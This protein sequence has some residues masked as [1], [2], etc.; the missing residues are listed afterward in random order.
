MNK[1]VRN[2]LIGASAAFAVVIAF[3]VAISH[4]LPERGT[5]KPSF[6]GM[7]TLINDHKGEENPYVIVEVVP[8]KRLAKLGYLVEGSEPYYYNE[9]DNTLAGWETGLE[10]Q[11]DAAARQK[12]MDGM[13][14]NL[15]SI[16]GSD[17]AL[18]YT[19]YKESYTSAK[20]YTELKLSRPEFLAKGTKGVDIVE[21]EGGEYVYDSSYSVAESDENGFHGDFDLNI[22]YYDV[23]ADN[24]YYNIGFQVLDENAD[25]SNGVYVINDVAMIDS[26]DAML[27]AQNVYHIEDVDHQIFSY[28]PPVDYENVEFEDGMFYELTFRY[29]TDLENND[30]TFYLPDLTTMSFKAD[31]TGQYGAVLNQEQ[32]YL[33]CP[34]EGHFV[35]TGENAYVYVGEGNGFY[36]LE[37]QDSYVLSSDVQLDHIYYT[38]GFSNNNLLR[39]SIFQDEK[40][41]NLQVKVVTPQELTMAIVNDADMLFLSDSSAYYHGEF[42]E[43]DKKNDLTA[44]AAYAIYAFAENNQ[45]PVIL[46]HNILSRADAKNLLKVATILEANDVTGYIGADMDQY[47]DYGA[48]EFVLIADDDH[49]FVSRNI[50][51]IPGDDQLTFL[52]NLSL[53]LCD[54]NGQKEDAFSTAAGNAGFGEIAQMMI[55]ENFIRQTENKATDVGYELFDQRITTATAVEYILS[56]INKREE[57]QVEELN[58]L[59]IEP[60]PY[61]VT[62]NYYGKIQENATAVAKQ[63]RIRLLLGVSDDMKL[64]ITQVSMAEFEGTVEDLC[65]YDV[66]YM[67]LEIDPKNS[68]PSPKTVTETDKNGKS[69]SVI[70]SD[71]NDNDMDGLV[72]TNIGDT[73]RNKHTEVL[74]TDYSNSKTGMYTGDNSM[75]SNAYNRMAGN[76]ITDEKLHALERVA[77]AGTPIILANNFLTTYGTSSEKVVYDYGHDANWNRD[78]SKNGYI[79][80]CSKVYTL[81]DDIKDYPNV[82]TEEELAS[83][84]GSTVYT[85]QQNLLIRY[86]ML[87]KPILTTKTADKVSGQNYV[88]TDGSTIKMDFS[89]AN[90]GSVNANATFDVVLYA[91]YNADGRFS[92]KTERIDANSYSVTLNGK[93]QD[94]T[95]KTFT[96]SRGE[97]FDDYCYELTPNNKNTTS[98]HLEYN[99]GSVFGLI[100]VKLKI[101]QSS[102]VNR[103][104]ADIIYFYHPNTAEKDTIRVLQLLPEKGFDQ[105]AFDM[106]LTESSE[107][108]FYVKY[109]EKYGIEKYKYQDGTWRNPY[110]Y[111][112]ASEASC[113]KKTESLGREAMWKALIASYKNSKFSEYIDYGV[114][115]GVSG[116]INDYTLDIDSVFGGDYC[117]VVLNEPDCLEDYDM[118]VLGFQDCYDFFAYSKAGWPKCVEENR[119]NAKAAYEPIHMF[120][121]SGKSVL[122][123]HDST[124]FFGKPGG[125]FSSTSWAVYTNE[126]MVPD[127]GMERYGV[128]SYLVD[129]AGIDNLTKGGKT[130]YKVSNYASLTKLKEEGGLTKSSYTSGELYDMVVD[131]ANQN[132][133]DVAYKPNSEKNVLVSQIH[134]LSDSVLRDEQY[135]RTTT[136]EMINEGQIL[137]YPYNLLSE[138]KEGYERWNSKTKNY[139]YKQAGTMTIASTH[140]QYFQLDMNADEDY[141]GESDTTV[142]FT[143]SGKKYDLTYREARNNYYVYTR[144]NITYSGVGHTNINPLDNSSKYLPEI[145]LYVNTLIAS[146]KGGTSKPTITIKQSDSSKSA[147]LSTV[148]VGTDYHIYGEKD[149]AEKGDTGSEGSIDYDYDDN[150]EDAQLDKPGDTE[151]LYFYISDT[152]R[153]NNGTKTIAV[154]YYQLFES[155]ADAKNH[156]AAGETVVNIGNEK[157][158]QY[159]IEKKWKTY[160]MNAKDEVA[161]ADNLKNGRIYCVK[162]PYGVL[163]EDQDYTKVRISVTTTIQYAATEDAL[164]NKVEKTLDVI[165]YDDVTVQ[166]AGLFDLE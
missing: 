87:G 37:Q 43:Y 38:G 9:N 154:N 144:G 147:D 19:E 65:K 46:D 153:V 27:E 124:S 12:Y 6:S 145:K 106:D 136:A 35:S 4:G 22:V 94:T 86:A 122:F 89:I 117:T 143:L 77:N 68:N 53:M 148:Y 14:E 44:E 95:L 52:D 114:D 93:E 70:R 155:E 121:E 85:S 100:P 161:N 15:S 131:Y 99:T 163:A 34:G 90:Y 48:E 137:V 123:T 36:A 72:Y 141:D 25:T 29:T 45:L 24:R 7:D 80:N 138:L 142:W 88:A 133:L 75:N 81:I 120:I 109:G 62:R 66:V 40:D 56:Y 140:C 156:A 115:K 128:Y 129:R 127:V 96:D 160:E 8:D 111:Y 82:M 110:E 125:S 2:W 126:Y 152:N 113:L 105:S 58:V 11:A 78:T 39:S 79:D 32:P 18:N 164:G 16:T 112:K 5:A 73:L 108:G 1:K 151:T 26:E 30:K 166:R 49:N 139:D 150:P 64:N 23:N 3:A 13:K 149:V 101:T 33:S 132:S 130:S 67:G 135:D 107:N 97:E 103:Y 84:D 31:A 61:T 60:F 134:G 21:K 98:Y 50:Y 42:S 104:D 51:V 118:L 165:G 63:N 57:Y 83:D 55:S 92:D 162:M 157:N 74:D 28:V 71:F 41:L 159:A 119:K 146:Y 47:N 20:D 158:P 54:G 76:D 91:D 102:N 69:I 17:K 116:M 10:Q 59:D